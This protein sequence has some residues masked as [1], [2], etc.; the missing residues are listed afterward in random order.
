M[1]KISESRLKKN[2]RLREI[3]KELADANRELDETL[4]E[5]RSKDKAERRTPD[6]LRELS[7]GMSEWAQ[8]ASHRSANWAIDDSR[9]SYEE[10]G[11]PL[12]AWQA[13][14][15]ARKADL[16]VPDWVLG[17]LDNVARAIGNVTPLGDK[18]VRDQAASALGLRGQGGGR[19]D[20]TRLDKEVLKLYVVR[21]FWLLKENSP[22]L[23]N[24][25]IFADLAAE[26][27]LDISQIS[28]WHNESL[29]KLD[30]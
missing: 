22:E 19:S 21:D 11:N 26:H 6:S 16:D 20:W 2:E 12:F 10:N 9:Q 24:W 25:E 27:D 28:K 23:S 29:K 14:E 7:I 8:K 30:Q 1:S 15:M 5:F 4:A 17:Y 18:R 3:R 13:Y